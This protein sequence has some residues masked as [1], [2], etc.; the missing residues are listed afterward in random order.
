MPPPIYTIPTA[1]PYAYEPHVFPWNLRRVPAF[2][3]DGKTP[4]P[5]R[6]CAIFVVHGIGDQ[7]WTTTSA[8]LRS[9]FEDAF[10]AIAA[11]QK[12][13]GWRNHGES[14]KPELLPPPFVFEG[15]WANYDNLQATFPEDWASFNEREREFFGTLWT[16]RVL[17]IKRTLVWFLKQQLRLLSFRVFKEVGLLAWILYWPL[18]VVAWATL[19]IALLRHPQVISGFLNDVRL[20]VQPEGMIERAIVQRIDFRVGEAFLRLIGLDWNFRPLAPDQQIDASGEPITFQRVIWVAHSLGTV[21]SY[22]VLSALFHRAQDLGTGGDAQQQEGIARFR[23]ALR[24][25]VTMGSPLDKIAFLFGE[26]AL[27]PWPTD[28]RRSLLDGGETLAEGQEKD[29]QEWWINFYH[30]L[31][32]VSGALSNPLICGDRPPANL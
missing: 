29:K 2:L 28:G 23:A 24:R 15:Y 6:T 20:Y 25:F 19:L 10:E 1:R 30:V 14:A 4:H 17:S 32:P 22:N 16:T 5:G 7:H 18:Q 26:Q 31:D 21:I 8:E 3:R 9:G 12:A 13:H 11:W 27:R